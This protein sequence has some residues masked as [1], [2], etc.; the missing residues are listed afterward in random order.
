[1]SWNTSRFIIGVLE[2]SG[3]RTVSELAEAGEVS[4]SSVRNSLSQMLAAGSVERL[5][6]EPPHRYALVSD[7]A[8]VAEAYLRRALD[9][10]LTGHDPVDEVQ[11]ALAVLTSTE[12]A[13]TMTVDELAQERADLRDRAAEIIEEEGPGWLTSG[14]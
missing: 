9:L 2:R 3:P 11:A 12:N 13:G 10:L 4:R 7:T 14:Q 5:G 6:A 1:M 8:P